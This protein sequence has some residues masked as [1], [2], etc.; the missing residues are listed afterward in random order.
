MIRV[1][2][3][4][5][6][7]IIRDGVKALIGHEKDIQVM[8]EAANGSELLDLLAQQPTDVAVIDINMPG[9]DGYEATR[10]ITE[11]HTQVKVVILSML[12]HESYINKMF[13]A[14]ALGYLLKNTGKEEFVYAI[15]MVAS[16][17]KY[18]CADIALNLLR[19]VSSTPA[20]TPTPLAAT[21]K[22]SNNDLSKREIEVLRLIADGLTNT[23]IAD[24]LFTSKRTIES[25]RQSLLEKTQSNNT[26]TLI[27][28]AV[29]NGL[30]E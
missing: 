10:R 26:A 27:R 25:H 13:D 29:L 30:V 5:D 9:M 2:L 24:K 8:G 18:I 7:K 17:Q 14:G 4:D 21:A 16:G 11:H 23:E 3:A 19:K 12:D 15:R 22:T 6:H 20:K 28:Y 1:V